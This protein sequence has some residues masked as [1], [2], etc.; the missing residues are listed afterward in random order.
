[1]PA[2]SAL[3]S[4]ATEGGAA[5]WPRTDV[6]DAMSIADVGGVFGISDAG[7]AALAGAG[8]LEV[9]GA[10]GAFS[11]WSVDDLAERLWRAAL[12]TSSDVAGVR[13][14]EAVEAAGAGSD[15]WPTVIAA[16][17]D[18]R[19]NAFRRRGA[20]GVPVV[21]ALVVSSERVVTELAPTSDSAGEAPFIWTPTPRR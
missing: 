9:A 17:L 21:A 19:I 1:M 18:G 7:V 15:R 16:L 6:A 3:A 14:C 12:P 10:P 11:R 8:L 20:S 2:I 5:V 13:L 4:D